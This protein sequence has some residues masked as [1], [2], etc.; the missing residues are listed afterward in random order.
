MSSS[1]PFSRA[2]LDA[3][4][5]ALQRGALEDAQGRCAAVLEK[6]PDYVD[7]LNLSALIAF[8][9]KRH[10]TALVQLERARTL[11]PADVQTLTSL[12]HV[13]EAAGDAAGALQAFDELLAIRPADFAARLHRGRVLE[14]LGRGDEV[15]FAYGRAIRD[16]QQQGRWVSEATTAPALKD[17]V[18][19]A[20]NLVNR[21]VGAY[22]ERAYAPLKARFGASEMQRVAHCLAMHLGQQPMELADARQQPT[23]LFLPG[24]PA[25]PYFDMAAMP[26]R[27]A[28]QAETPAIIEELQALLPTSNGREAVFHSGELAEENLRGANAQYGSPSWSGYYF[29]RHGEARLENHAACPRTA[30][31]LQALPLARIPGHAPEVL[32]SVFSPG[33]HLLPHRGVT[34]TRVVGHLPLIVPPDC[35]LRV[36]GETHVW[37]QGEAVVFDDTYEH[38]AWNRSGET[39]VVLIF[40]LWNPYLTEAERLAISAL[41]VAMGDYRAATE[42]VESASR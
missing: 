11:A 30:A 3:A 23:F 41:V 27:E 29:Y 42:P 6:S 34:N 18:R 28:L 16:A 19:H 26:W 4:R 22:Y 2:A 1:N 38:E 31:A 10:S 35:A 9:Q 25:T 24:L 5:Q 37:K 12:G 13:R 7:A 15:L 39:R 32:F 14:Q 17:Q 8:R 21:G 20:I 40:D 33:T 36:G